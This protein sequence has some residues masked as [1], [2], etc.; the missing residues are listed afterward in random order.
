MHQ[1]MKGESY[2]YYGYRIRGT[3]RQMPRFFSY[4]IESK[5]A[6]RVSD[7]RTRKITIRTTQGRLRKGEKTR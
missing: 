3:K 7:Y 4:K 5:Y 1:T 6:E 2:C